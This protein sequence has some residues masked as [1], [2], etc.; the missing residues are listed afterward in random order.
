MMEPIIN[1]AMELIL[2]VSSFWISDDEGIIE[3]GESAI[4]VVDLTSFL[5]LFWT[6]TGRSL[7][8]GL[9][10]SK[11]G[12]TRFSRSGGSTEIILDVFSTEEPFDISH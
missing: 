12:T 1:Q 9:T 6:V 8:P 2:T 11:D 5:G 3:T 7:L 10:D 4:S